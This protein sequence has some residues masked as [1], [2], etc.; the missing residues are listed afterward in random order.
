MIGTGIGL[1]LS[2]YRLEPAGF[3]PYKIAGLQLWLDASDQS[4]LY[5]SS[6]GSLATADGDPVGYWTD[7][8][9][10][11]RHATQ[12]DGT[13]KPAIKLGVQNNRNAILFDGSNDRLVISNSTSSLSFLHQ[14]NSSIF[15]VFRYS[16]LN[17]GAVFDS[18]GGASSKRGIS[19][20]VRS[21]G[22]ADFFITNGT[23]TGTSGAVVFNLSSTSYI[24]S[25]FALLSFINQPTNST[26]A[27]RSFGYKNGGSA[28]N[29]NASTGSISAAN[30]THN[31]QIGEW[32]GGG[33]MN[34]YISEIVIYNQSLS[35]SDRSVVEGYLLTK[36][37]L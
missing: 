12:T 17:E 4:T 32:N 24:S 16:T 14:S 31:M 25:S 36:W 6:G 11:A 9:G 22:N 35:S 26:L 27:N 15:I 23:A 8:S 29:N 5:Q 13:K 7:K 21:T 10:N 19:L 34:G 2:G 1:G 37:G 28:F 3:T 33:S 30:A 18:T 20:Y